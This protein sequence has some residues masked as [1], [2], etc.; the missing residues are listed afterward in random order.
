MYSLADLE[1]NLKMLIKELRSIEDSIAQPQRLREKN[2]KTVMLRIPRVIL[3]A[4][5]CPFLS[6]QDIN[7]LSNTCSGMRKIIYSPIG[8]KILTKVKTPYPIKVVEV[9]SEFE[10]KMKKVA[11][12]AYDDPHEDYEDEKY[13][14]QERNKYK[15]ILQKKFVD[16]LKSK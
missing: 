6:M 12:E 15:R 13:I 7:S 9:K 14:E 1:S 4:R 5:I 16:Y 8:F 2:S 10:K 3:L 11:M